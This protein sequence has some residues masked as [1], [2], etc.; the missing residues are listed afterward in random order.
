MDA[1]YGIVGIFFRSNKPFL[2]RDMNT[3]KKYTI[4]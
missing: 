4:E 2:H 1:Y 3:T